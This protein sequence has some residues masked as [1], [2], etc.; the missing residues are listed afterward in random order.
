MKQ[1]NFLLIL[2]L[3]I[4]PV[5]S[6]FGMDGDAQ[7]DQAEGVSSSDRVSIGFIQGLINGI[8]IA[9]ENN[10]SCSI[11]KAEQLRLEC[12]RLEAI[13]ARIGSGETVSKKEI[14]GEDDSEDYCRKWSEQS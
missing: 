2:L 11:K 14:Y 1:T 7:T 5:F 8:R 9:L 4:A 6:C 10:P 3:S 12:L 13:L